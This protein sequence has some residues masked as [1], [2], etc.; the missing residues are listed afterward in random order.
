MRTVIED[1]DDETPEPEVDTN[2]AADEKALLPLTDEQRDLVEQNAGLAYHWANRFQHSVPEVEYDDIAQ[3]ALLGLAKAARMWD[4]LPI[5]DKEG[6]PFG[7]YAGNAIRNFLGNYYHKQKKYSDNEFKTLDAPIGGGDDDEGG[8]ETHSDVLE[9][10]ESYKSGEKIA[11]KKEAFNTIKTELNKLPD[12]DRSVLKQWMSGKSY[13]E[14]QPEFGVSFVQIGMWAR[15]GMLKL[16]AALEAKGIKMPSDL[17]PESV[18]LDGK[19]VKARLVESIAKNL[20]ISSK[21]VKLA[22]KLLA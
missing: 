7:R 8:D 6:L 14:M 18:E 10:P 19:V 3:Q 5:T 9:D 16:K 2:V 20:Y 21:A 1:I 22:E 13:R 11:A 15:R 4:R 17:L 12:P